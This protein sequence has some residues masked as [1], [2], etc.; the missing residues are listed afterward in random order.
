[1]VIVWVFSAERH[2]FWVVL[3]LF[4]EV[5]AQPFHVQLALFEVSAGMILERVIRFGEHLRGSTQCQSLG[6]VSAAG[7][8]IAGACIA[9]PNQPPHDDCAGQDVGIQKRR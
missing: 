9:Q 2:S 8:G 3:D 7:V 6:G 5:V 4:V 1:M